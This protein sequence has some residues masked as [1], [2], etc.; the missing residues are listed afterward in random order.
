VVGLTTYRQQAKWASWDRPGAIVNA[1]YVDCVANAGARPVLLPP[2]EGAGVSED[3]ESE[4]ARVLDALIIIGGADVEPSRYGAQR[5]DHTVA[6]QPW[7]DENELRLVAAFIEAGKPVLGICRGAQILNTFLGGTLIQHLPDVTGRTTHQPAPGVFGDT[8]VH[9]E[10]GTRVAKAMGEVFVVK[11]CHHQAVDTLG[12]GLRVVARSS[13]G[14][15]E[16]VE[17][18]QGFVVGAQWHPEEAGDTRL[19]R[20]LVE[21]C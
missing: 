19:F 7:R 8:E 10:A 2:S 5:D 9:S 13:D 11:C 3:S 12:E 16:A 14:V 17:L 21:A 18:D 1:S 15:V 4:V 20:A 6:T